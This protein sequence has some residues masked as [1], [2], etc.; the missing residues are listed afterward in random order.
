[1]NLIRGKL[2]DVIAFLDDLTCGAASTRGL[3]EGR[4][5]WERSLKEYRSGFLGRE[6]LC[7]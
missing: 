4:R 1:V 7:R 5:H 3:E 2:G 6:R